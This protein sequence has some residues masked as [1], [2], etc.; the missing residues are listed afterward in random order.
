MLRVTLLA[1]LLPTLALAQGSTDVPYQGRLMD[2]AGTPLSTIASVTFKLFRSEDAGSD[3]TALWSVTQSLGLSDGYYSTLLPLPL[4]LF[5]GSERYLEL[6]VG[7]QRLQPR[8]RDRLDSL[9]R[10]VQEC[11]RD[12]CRDHGAPG[13]GRES[14]DWIRAPE[15]PS[16]EHFTHG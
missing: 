8:L 7:E 5:D 14:C 9:C 12:Q 6:T 1:L 2:S 10:M 11:R 4:E 15:R 3:K 16:S 13:D